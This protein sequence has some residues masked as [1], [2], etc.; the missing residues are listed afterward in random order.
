MRDQSSPP[1]RE[2]AATMEAAGRWLMVY[3][4]SWEVAPAWPEGLRASLNTFQA[5][6]SESYANANGVLLEV[7]RQLSTADALAGALQQQ[8]APWGLDPYGFAFVLATICEW[9]ALRWQIVAPEASAKVGS[10]WLPWRW[11]FEAFNAQLGGSLDAQFAPSIK[12]GPNKTKKTLQL[13]GR[14]D[15]L[16]GSVRNP[17]HYT[18]LV[19]YQLLGYSHHD[20]LV[21]HEERAEAL[22]NERRAKGDSTPLPR[23]LRPPGG[24]NTVGKEINKL[25]GELGVVLRAPASGGR[26]R[27]K[28]PT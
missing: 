4:I 11:L 19:Q 20:I 10:T 24:E 18:W 9:A 3:N 14:L 27:T 15:P 7:A 26:P 1:A 6:Y 22:K 28:P 21:D 5:C 17:N 2:S 16:G 12:W 13:M 25:A 23:W 8:A